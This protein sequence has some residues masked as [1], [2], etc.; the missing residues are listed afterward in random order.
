ML[1]SAESDQ[2]GLDALYLRAKTGVEASE[3]SF[4]P[5]SPQMAVALTDFAEQTLNQGHLKEARALCKR[6]M[7]IWSNIPDAENHLPVAKTAYEMA[8]LCRL[9]GEWELAEVCYKSSLEVF[10][11]V[12]GSKHPFVGACLNS[13]GLLEVS[14]GQFDRAEPLFREALAFFEEILGP[15]NSALAPIFNN[16]GRTLEELGKQTEAESL[17]RRA[18]AIQEKA[19]GPE[20]PELQQT[21][22]NLAALYKT[23]G[24]LAS[25]LLFAARAADVQRKNNSH[26]DKSDDIVDLE[27]LVEA[28]RTG[29]EAGGS[30][31]SPCP[32]GHGMWS[33]PG[34][35]ARHSGQCEHDTS[36]NRGIPKWRIQTRGSVSAQSPA[37]ASDGTLLLAPSNRA[38]AL[39]PNGTLLWVHDLEQSS[40]ETAPYVCIGPEGILYTADGV[41][42][43][44]MHA[45]GAVQRTIQMISVMGARLS[46]PTPAPDGTVYFPPFD[47]LFDKPMLTA[48]DA[49]GSIKWQYATQESSMSSVV[50]ALDGTVYTETTDGWLYAV[51]P[52]GTL[53]WKYET[54]N[55]GMC[56][57]AVSTD[58][59]VYLGSDDHYVL[60]INSD[61]TLRWRYETSGRRVSSPAVGRDGTVFVGSADGRLHALFPGGRVKWKYSIDAECLPSAAIGGDGTLYVA[62]S[63][64][65]RLLALH[66]DG[67]LKWEY[68]ADRPVWSPPSIAA[69]GTL[70]LMTGDGCLQALV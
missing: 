14:R 44:A 42:L 6:A 67:T 49:E 38:Y 29:A 66:P 53:K 24:K 31:D 37:V 34:C 33:M 1:D 61:G 65:R 10:T 27:G 20:S 47:V 46:R 23:Q 36:R 62:T 5:N 17:Y 55:P 21:Y 15:E 52:D 60:A 7:L 70:Y 41:N 58:G 26:E 13:L 40:A 56:S 63:L 39:Q 59:T 11:R 25:A 28:H 48:I 12:G 16:L 45:D 4:G 32:Q 64:D 18:S 19:C 51:H 9:G 8:D 54:D 35:D 68:K 43:I 69:D 57:P 2:D 22:M 3:Q 30:V 50:V